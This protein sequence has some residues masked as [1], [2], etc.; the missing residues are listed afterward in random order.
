MFQT[1]VLDL[2]AQPLAPGQVAD[3][4]FPDTTLP[5]TLHTMMTGEATV[6]TMSV[7]LPD[8]Y[9]SSKTFPLL[10]Y[11]GTDHVFRRGVRGCACE[12]PPDMGTEIHRESVVL[13][14]F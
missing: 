10:V 5:P 13:L 2:L 14:V 7:R 6:P 12:R 1:F 11:Y 4:S 9:D 8:D 3:I